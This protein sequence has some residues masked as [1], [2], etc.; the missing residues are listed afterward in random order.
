MSMLR[1]FP[2]HQIRPLTSL[3]GAWE[4]L[5]EC[6]G[7]PKP[8]KLPN[9][10]PRVLEVPMPWE[11]MPDLRGYRGVGWYRKTF[12]LAK[13]GCIRLAFGGVSHTAQVWVDGTSVGSHYDAFTPWDVVVP[14]LGAGPHQVVLRVD[15]TFGAH[16]ALHLPN[17]YY[18]YGGI[19]RPVELQEV[20]GLFLDKLLATPRKGRRGW[21]LDVRVRVRHA[22]VNL[23]QSGARVHLKVAGTEQTVSLP[24]VDQGNTGEVGLTLKGLEVTPWSETSP[25]LY[26]LEATL[27]RDGEI[28]DDLRERV[29]F[30]EVRVKGDQLLLNGAKV[31]LRGFNRHEDAP[32]FGCSVPLTLMAHDLDLIRDMNC[33]FL[34][35][36]HYP[37]DARM[38]DLCD[39]RGIYVWEESHSRATPFDHPRFM[40]QIRTSTIEMVESHFNH[41]SVL[42]W[43][44]LN[45][46]DSVTEN[47]YKVHR[48]I[49]GLLRE[50]DAT[51]PVTYATNKRKN[52]TCLGL[53]DIVSLNIYTGWYR[54]L[55]EQTGEVFGDMLAWLDSDKSHGGKGKPVIMS[56]F[57]GGAIYGVRNPQQDLW[58]EDYQAHLLDES[59]KAYLRHPRI[60]GTAIWQFC[61]VRTTRESKPDGEYSPM[62]RP[63]TMNNKGVVDEFRRP[64]LAYTVVKKRMAQAIR[65]RGRV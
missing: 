61:D 46:C 15:N 52:D 14:D 55:P 51:R 48:E 27:I 22:G 36:C 8:G 53:A 19:T 28:V 37:N 6:D 12:T 44:S 3:D 26:L 9:R 4:F 23:K 64:K 34:R 29:G 40:E 30:R 24:E 57:G 25:T 5:P 63:R 11:S 32:V 1:T 47:G 59:L 33:N 18:T 54:H 16:S 10:F 50:L 43:G 31:H 42:M 49:M 7:A 62:K 13:P 65:L 17:D 21:N 60:V 38:L 56:E 41:P 2:Q 39:E 20:P 45:E 58:S 35:T